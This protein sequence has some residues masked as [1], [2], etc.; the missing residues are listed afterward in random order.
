MQGLVTLIMNS[1]YG[2]QIGKDINDSYCC[3]SEHWV[4][5]QHKENVSD[6][7]KFPNGIFI[8]EMK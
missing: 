1:V 5:T 8:V 4:E 3:K 7:W 2:V 6:H